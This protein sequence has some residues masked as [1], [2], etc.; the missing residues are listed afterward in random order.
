M[1]NFTFEKIIDICKIKDDEVDE[2]DLCPITM[3]FNND[4]YEKE[5]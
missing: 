5:Y 3:L 2:N 4:E 1:S